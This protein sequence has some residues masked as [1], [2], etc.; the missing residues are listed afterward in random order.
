MRRIA[1][2]ALIVGL[3]ISC[4][5]QKTGENTYKVIAPTPEAKSAAEKAKVEAKKA[6]EKL[7]E[8]AG[9]AAHKT[10]TAL[11]HAGRQIEQHTKT[12][13]TKREKSTT[14]R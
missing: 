7:K 4:K 1:M 6:G 10:G 8:E 9:V 14:Y 12:E 13:T 11:E 3:A 5:V 2:L